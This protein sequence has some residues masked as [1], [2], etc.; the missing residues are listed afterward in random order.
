[1]GVDY[2]H[3]IL[4][5]EDVFNVQLTSDDVP[6]LSTPG[7]F[8]DFLHDRFPKAAV[9]SC[10]RK[11]VF[12]RIRSGL[13]ERLAIPLQDITESMYLHRVTRPEL[14]KAWEEIGTGLGAR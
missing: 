7:S 10:L 6:R 14:G 12:E 1:M 11:R 4:I 8:I 3:F 13:S 9:E 2:L 5:V